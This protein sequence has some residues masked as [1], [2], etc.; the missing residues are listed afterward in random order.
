MNDASAFVLKLVSYLICINGLALQFN[1]RA[2]RLRV[3]EYISVC[4][5]VRVRACVHGC[6]YMSVVFT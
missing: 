3:Y 2:V 4:V 6:L 1:L 5:C